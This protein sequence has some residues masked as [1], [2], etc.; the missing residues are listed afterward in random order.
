MSMTDAAT[1]PVAARDTSTHTRLPDGWVLPARIGWGLLVSLGIASYVIARIAVL[2]DPGLLAETFFGTIA[3][4]SL[5][6]FWLSD[7]PITFGYCLIGGFLMWRGSRDWLVIL[8]SYA[9]IGLGTFALSDTSRLLLAHSRSVLW[10]ALILEALAVSGLIALFYLFP[11]GRFTPPWT[12]W[13]AKACSF[14]S[15]GSDG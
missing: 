9:L 15:D 4:G 8:V 6:K 3:D 1:V 10:P 12:R 11:D 2:N 14:L 5:W 13:L 7:L